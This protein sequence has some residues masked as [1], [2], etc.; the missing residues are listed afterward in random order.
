MQTVLERNI[1]PNP[2]K[3]PYLIPIDLEDEKRVSLRTEKVSFISAI[4][5]MFVTDRTLK[6]INAAKKATADSFKSSINVEDL[7]PG[8]ATAR[9]RV[10]FNQHTYLFKPS[11]RDTYDKSSKAAKGLWRGLPDLMKYIVSGILGIV[12]IVIVIPLLYCFF[13]MIT[14]PGELMK[15]LLLLSISG[16]F[17]FIWIFYV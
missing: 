1:V 4:A 14:K 17:V 5:S 12:F 10:F 2:D 13:T 8:E 9:E 6:K 11:S 16:V 3:Q 7:I 15:V